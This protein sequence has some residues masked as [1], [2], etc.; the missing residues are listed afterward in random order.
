MAWQVLLVKLPDALGSLRDLPADFVPQSLGAPEYV[1]ER[2]AD[3]A[4]RA[5]IT[6]DATEN[7]R[8]LIMRNDEFVIEAEL[9][10]MIAVDRVLLNVLGSDAALPLVG[11][12]A[13]ALDTAA[14]DCETD[15]VLDAD[16]IVPDTLRQWQIRI[17][18]LR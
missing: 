10:G 4:G 9:G 13:R 17:D 6:L 16:S 8:L 5:N 12:L 3:A 7:D 2:I 15:S 1:A 14:I 18:G 11:A